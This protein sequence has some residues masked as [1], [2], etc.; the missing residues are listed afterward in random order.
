MSISTIV[1]S[2]FVGIASALTVHF[3]SRSREHETWIRDCEKEEWRELLTALAKAELAVLRIGN[4]G[5]S[6]D[7]TDEKDEAWIEVYGEVMRVMLD[8][9]YI[10]DA[11]MRIRLISRWT[12]ATR[13]FE[14]D[15]DA[16]AVT[17]QFTEIKESLIQEATKRAPKTL[18]S[19]F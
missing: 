8:R 14:R 15:Y 6:G 5:K 9:I 17:T 11:M 13:Q 2:F 4:S 19:R 16:A 1:L 18:L 10:V 3:L 7:L 12:A